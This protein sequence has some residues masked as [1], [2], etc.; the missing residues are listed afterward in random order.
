MTDRDVLKIYLGRY[1]RALEKISELESERQQTEENA[2][3]I[4]SACNFTYTKVKTN[5]VNKQ[6]ETCAVKAVHIE[7]KINR[8]KAQLSGI[9]NDVLRMINFLP[10]E[11][12]GYCLLTEKFLYCKSPS[13]IMSDLHITKSGYYNRYNNTLEI[14]LQNKEIREVL[15]KYKEAH[16]VRR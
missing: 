7:E 1:S 10:I 15:K 6:A 13:Q 9:R 4:K 14:L 2:A 16:R 5:S 11:A 8:I 12:D 3:A